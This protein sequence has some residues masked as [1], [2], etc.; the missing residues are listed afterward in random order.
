MSSRKGENMRRKHTREELTKL[1]DFIREDLKNPKIVCDSTMK[2]PGWE[3]HSYIVV[4]ANVQE[5]KYCPWCGKE[6]K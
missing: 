1:A 2:C 3:K 6:I 4:Y 5:W